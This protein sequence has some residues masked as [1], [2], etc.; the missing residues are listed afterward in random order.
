MSRQQRMTAKQV[1]IVNQEIFEQMAETLGND[2]ADVRGALEATLATMW[3]ET[4][5]VLLVWWDNVRCGCSTGS[6]DEAEKL[7]DF[8]QENDICIKEIT[9]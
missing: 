3:A 1:T 6:R 8:F 9:I 7:I 5:G 2:P 4:G